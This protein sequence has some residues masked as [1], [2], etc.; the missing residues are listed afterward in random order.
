M[1]SVKV[2]E[3]SGVAFDWAAAKAAIGADRWFQKASLTA[4]LAL[5]YASNFEMAEAA[6]RSK[7]IS[8][9]FVHPNRW[10]ASM[11]KDE[12]L[13]LMPGSTPTRAVMRCLIVSK[14]GESIDIPSDVLDTGVR[15]SMS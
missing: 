12:K 4:I 5:R 13:H 14:F 7:G 3:L 15:S 8:V 10:H 9:E 6:M 1:S 2:R 11:G